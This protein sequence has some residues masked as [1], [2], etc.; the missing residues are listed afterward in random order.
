MIGQLHDRMQALEDQRDR[1][2]AES[3]N[4]Q[5]PPKDPFLR[6]LVDTT[7]EVQ[8]PRLVAQARTPPPNLDPQSD[9]ELGYWA[10]NP[11]A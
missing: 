2:L 10:W 4:R 1:A 9:G 8:T 3:T 11:H 7:Y 6:E 5:P